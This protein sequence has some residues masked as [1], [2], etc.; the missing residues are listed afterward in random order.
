[1]AVNPLARSQK[2]ALKMNDEIGNLFTAVGTQAHPRGFVSTAYR[3]AKRAMTSALQEGDPTAAARDVFQGLR[4]TI[5]SASLSLF[6]DAQLLGMEESAR[7]LKYYDIASDTRLARADRLMSGVALDAILARIDA[8]DATVRALILTGADPVQIIGD[9]ERAGILR[10]SDLAPAISSMA[11]TLVWNAFS[12]WTYSYSSDVTFRKQVIA[13]LDARTTD[14]CL[15][16]HGQIQP[17]DKPFKLTGEPRF[18]DQM[19]WSPFHWYCRTS[20][21]LYL[22]GYDDGLTDRLRSGADWFLRE[23]A[24]GRMPDRDPANAF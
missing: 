4:S 7:Q 9:D 24:A 1:M 14:C 15:R 23:R 16:A 12:D 5:R 17:L 22:E 6:N 21:S 19:D 13:A 18:A 10:P 2:S 8:Q 20:I 11:A 3:N